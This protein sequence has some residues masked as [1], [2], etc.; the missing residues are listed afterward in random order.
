VGNESG[1][2]EQNAQ[3][4]P[5]QPSLNSVQEAIATGAYSVEGDK[6]VIKSNLKRLTHLSSNLLDRRSS[7]L[8]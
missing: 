1:N 6:E 4:H 5:P 3:I 7:S 2:F 8:G